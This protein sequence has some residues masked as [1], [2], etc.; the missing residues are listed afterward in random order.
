MI[1]HKRDTDAFREQVAV[2]LH[3]GNAHHGGGKRW[4]FKK[5]LHSRARDIPRKFGIVDAHEPLVA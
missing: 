5:Q 3:N 2:D 4:L 1:A